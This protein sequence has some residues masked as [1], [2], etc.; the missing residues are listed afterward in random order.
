MSIYHKHHIIPRHMGGSDDPSNLVIVTIEEHANLHKQLW[1]DLGNEYDLI[2]Y[3]FLSGLIPNEVAR[4]ESVRAANKCKPKSEE[5]RR[6]ISEARKKNW[7]T[8]DALRSKL[9][10]INMGNTRGRAKAGWIPTEETKKRMSQSAKLRRKSIVSCDVC[11]KQMNYNN[12][13]IHKRHKHQ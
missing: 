12:L 8:N 6:K 4:I 2:A 11:G 7:E 5:H 1:E 9:S 10:K 13:S 3:K